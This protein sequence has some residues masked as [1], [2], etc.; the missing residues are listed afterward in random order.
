MNAKSSIILENHLRGVAEA[1]SL[2]TYQHYCR[3]M[4]ISQKI[5]YIYM[6]VC[7]CVCVCLCACEKHEKALKHLL[8]HYLYIYGISSTWVVQLVVASTNEP[9][10]FSTNSVRSIIQR[11]CNMWLKIR[12]VLKFW[13]SKTSVIYIWN[14]ETNVTSCIPPKLLCGNSWTWAYSVWLHGAGTNELKMCLM[15]SI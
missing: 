1:F 14:H 10:K 4:R 6:C 8:C 7:V 12:K 5:I 2:N 3:D 9:K 13:R 11:T 15:S